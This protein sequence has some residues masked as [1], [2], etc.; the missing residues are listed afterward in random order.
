VITDTGPVL[1]LTE[2]AALDLLGLTGEVSI[3]P[4]AQSELRIHLPNWP[5][6]HPPWLAV[7]PLGGAARAEA[8]P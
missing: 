3:P 1:H 6:V 2:A 4:D 5:G 7:I 8:L